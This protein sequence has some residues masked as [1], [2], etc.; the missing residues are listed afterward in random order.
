MQG[1]HS[2][3][4][5]TTTMLELVRAF[6]RNIMHDDIQDECGF[7]ELA[8]VETLHLDLPLLTTLTKHWD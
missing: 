5:M 4:P 8:Y 6:L 1:A 3:G 2:R 7:L